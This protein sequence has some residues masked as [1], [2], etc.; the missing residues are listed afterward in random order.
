MAII[1]A[2]E[3]NFNEIISKDLVLVD[4]FANWCGPCKML[5]PILENLANSRDGIKIIKVDVDEKAYTENANKVVNYYG[6]Y[7][8]DSYKIQFRNGNDG[9]IWEL[10]SEGDIKEDL[11]NAQ[12]Q[13]YG[14]VRSL[15]AKVKAYDVIYKALESAINGDSNKLIYLNIY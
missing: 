8:T 4:F 7:S 12:T 6:K 3:E 13:F 10:K 2:K 1:H 5:S 15:D 9:L 14:Y 11:T